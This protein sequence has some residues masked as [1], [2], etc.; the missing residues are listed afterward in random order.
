MNKINFIV[1]FPGIE[2][3]I[4]K[5]EKGNYKVTRGKNGVTYEYSKEFKSYMIS[6]PVSEI[7][8]KE[9]HASIMNAFNKIESMIR[10][11]KLSGNEYIMLVMLAEAKKLYLDMIINSNNIK[12]NIRNM[13]NNANYKY[14]IYDNKNHSG[15]VGLYISILEVE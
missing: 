14:H 7:K 3:T 11:D 2:T 12:T 8:Y 5:D 9:S 1:K 15:T 10:N 13:I 4:P 6:I